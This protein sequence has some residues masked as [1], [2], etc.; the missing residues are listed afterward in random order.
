MKTCLTIFCLVFSLVLGNLA[1]E[2]SA[3]LEIRG[4]ITAVEENSVTIQ[5]LAGK[6]W[7]FEITQDLDVPLKHLREHQKQKWPVSVYYQTKEDKKVAIKI[8]D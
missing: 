1:A 8:T 4:L 2:E 3:K 6:N 5:D 7:Q